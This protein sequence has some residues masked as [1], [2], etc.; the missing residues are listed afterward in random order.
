MNILVSIAAIIDESFKPLLF[1]LV[2]L[3]GA[4]SMG[5]GVYLLWYF[6]KWFYDNK[7]KD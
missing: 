2:I 3:G 1:L 5:L 7:R 6:W 4:L